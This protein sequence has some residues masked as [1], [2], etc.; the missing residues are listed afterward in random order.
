MKV[1]VILK[2]QQFE[3]A[4]AKSNLTIE[5]IC[6]KVGISRGYLSIVKNINKPKH[7]LG[8]KKRQKLLK[9]LK[10]KYEDIFDIV[11]EG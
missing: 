7:N 5:E 4:V 8:T 9:I 11:K 2:P 6:D 1:R 10:V 3:E